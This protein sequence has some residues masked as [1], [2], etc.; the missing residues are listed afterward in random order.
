L[1]QFQQPKSRILFKAVLAFANPFQEQ[2][3]WTGPRPSQAP[4]DLKGIFLKIPIFEA[5]S[6]NLD[7]KQ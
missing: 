1:W 5:A 3:L 4:R 2:T 7:E 6:K